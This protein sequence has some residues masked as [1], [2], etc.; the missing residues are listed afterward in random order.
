LTHNAKVYIA[1]RSQ[2]KVEAAIQDLKNST[3]KEAIFLKL[4]LADLKSVKSAAEEY[5]RFVFRRKAGAPLTLNSKETKLDVLF[6][7][8]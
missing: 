6:N 7:N 4:D 3:G 5:L 2:E 1:A 8:A